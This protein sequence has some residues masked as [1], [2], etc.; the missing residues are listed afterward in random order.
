MRE[1]ESCSIRTHR[2]YIQALIASL[3]FKIVLQWTFDG[4]ISQRYSNYC[5]IQAFS[6]MLNLKSA[7]ASVWFME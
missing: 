4:S 5:L 1:Q 6:E 3:Y 2:I 7:L